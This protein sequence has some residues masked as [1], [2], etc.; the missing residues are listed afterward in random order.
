MTYVD[1]Y[2]AAVPAT[3]KD[4]YIEMSRKMSELFPEYGVSRLVASWGDDVPEGEL[5]S[6]PRALQRQ[7]DEE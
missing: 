5:T 7:D 6:F 4:A 1:A 3:N 2:I